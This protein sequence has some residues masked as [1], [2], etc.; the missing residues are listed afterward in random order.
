MISDLRRKGFRVDSILGRKKAS[1][2]LPHS[3]S[4]NS[5][6]VASPSKAVSEYSNEIHIKIE[7]IDISNETDREQ[8]LNSSP[9]RT[10]NILLEL[11]ASTK[12]NDPPT[13]VNR[14][15]ILL[16]KFSKPLASIDKSTRRILINKNLTLKFNNFKSYHL[17]IR[18]TFSGCGREFATLITLNKLP[19]S[20]DDYTF[21]LTELV[22]ESLTDEPPAKK[23]NKVSNNNKPKLL[24]SD[25]LLENYLSSNMIR[26]KISKSIKTHN[27]V[28]KEKF[29]HEEEA[30]DVLHKSLSSVLAKFNDSKKN[31]HAPRR[32]Y[33]QFTTVPASSS[34]KKDN[35]KNNKN[36]SKKSS[37]VFQMNTENFGFMCPFC[38]LN[39]LNSLDNLLK[40]LKSTHFRFN[41]AKVVTQLGSRQTNGLH[42]LEYG[43]KSNN[44]L[45]KT[46]TLIEI[47]LD[48]L[49]DG[50]YLGKKTKIHIIF[51]VYYQI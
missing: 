9:S 38:H 6:V 22:D 4:K 16:M 44:L 24:T 7:S 8:F 13:L 31:S 15:S 30:L 5:S 1:L 43:S 3:P 10:N 19:M 47:S 48:D 39:Q 20:N 45:G 28:K 12:L 26:I 27:S 18:V 23:S 51:L 37:K 49:F 36:Q 42:S 21:K 41:F 50:S 29:E 35:K 17:L 46:V 2:S 32:V 33:Y 11:F 14:D 34:S 40:H 25:S